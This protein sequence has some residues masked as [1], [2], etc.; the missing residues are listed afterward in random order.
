MHTLGSFN[1]LSS[2]RLMRSRC[3]C[4]CLSLEIG[5]VMDLIRLT[6]R[7]GYHHQLKAVRAMYDD[8]GENDIQNRVAWQ[9]ALLE[10]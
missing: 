2:R 1:L 7:A 9:Q 10:V 5:Q 3:V 4:F 6:F 8:N